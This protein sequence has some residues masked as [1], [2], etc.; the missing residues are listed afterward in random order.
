MI[1][2]STFST[3]PLSSVEP[4]GSP[5]TEAAGVLRDWVS[6]GQGRGRAARRYVTGEQS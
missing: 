4:F 1:Q 6:G 3:E 5:T 2:E